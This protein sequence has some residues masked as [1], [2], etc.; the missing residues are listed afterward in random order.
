MRSAASAAPGR[1]DLATSVERSTLAAR[2]SGRAWEDADDAIQAALADRDAADDDLDPI[3]QSARTTRAGRGISAGRE[4]PYTL[5]FPAG[6]GYYIAAPLD[7][8]TKRYELRARLEQNLP[9]LRR[10]A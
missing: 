8:N 2:E 10:R 1:T 7:E 4:A 9:A 6:I 3:A 5:I